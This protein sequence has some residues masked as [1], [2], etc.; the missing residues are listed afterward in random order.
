MSAAL[1]SALYDGVVQHRRF[2]SAPH[3]FRYGLNLLYLDL[4]EVDEVFDLHP[5]WSATRPAPVR[6]RRDDYLGDPAFPLD[7]SVRDL[8]ER[9]QGAR[10][11]GPVRLL[12][13]VRTLGWCFNPIMLY[14]CFDPSGQTVE[15]LVV[16]VTNTP[17]GETHTYVVADG[18]DGHRHEF[19][20]ALHV[21][22]FMPMDQR[23]S[24]RASV[25]ADRA[26]IHLENRRD[27]AR[28]FDAHL[29]VRRTEIDRRA[30]G[31]RLV[32]HPLSSMKIS[33][34]IYWEALR[35][36]RRGAPYHRHPKHVDVEVVR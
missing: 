31:S 34:A 25:P 2:G 29:L 36:W 19:D 24:L 9:E 5:L 23:Y 7:T 13:T 35:L 32:R 16:Q 12:A 10:P 28:V 4:A 8:V 3:R 11:T 6:F 30:L 22:P 33:A 26:Y 15:T 27:G 18:A 14:Y 17:W 1:T 20:K 21:S